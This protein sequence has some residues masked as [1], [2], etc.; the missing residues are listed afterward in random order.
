[1][2]SLNRLVMA[3]DFSSVSETA[4]AFALTL[5]T[6][7]HTEVHLITVDTTEEGR[8]TNE[9][10]VLLQRVAD[11]VRAHHQE[12]VEG[13]EGTDRVLDVH[14][15]V[16]TGSDAAEAILSYAEAND[17]D[18]V[19]TGT[20]GRRGVSRAVLGSVAT[21]VV[22]EAPCPVLTV[23]ETG[24]LPLRAQHLL[25]PVDF[26]TPSNAAVA[27]A[28]AL[29]EK[30]GARLTVV[31]VMEKQN[32][33]TGYGFKPSV[34]GTAEAY[35]RARKDLAD[36]VADLP[37]DAE[38]KVLDGKPAQAITAFATAAGVDGI[39][40]STRGNSGMKR[41]LSGSVTEAV[42]TSAPCPVLV[43]RDFV[44]FVATEVQESEDTAA[45]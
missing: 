41:M 28:G 7:P 20:R 36:L 26:S 35:K 30:I 29:A 9:A 37:I 1:M 5:T 10:S 11:G 4:A 23:R 13:T 25:V 45:K 24:A 8:P 33:N 18:M 32:G 43:A 22:R 40:M 3:T 12:L 17:A 19:V 31:Y 6:E 42:M 14:P 21:A 39:V 27:Y 38:V 15:H 2:K 44:P 34:F 16:I